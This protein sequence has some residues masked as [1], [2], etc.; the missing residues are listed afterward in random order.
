MDVNHSVAHQPP[1]A[2]P[3]VLCSLKGEEY[4]KGLIRNSGTKRSA[5]PDPFPYPVVGADH[6]HSIFELPIA[7]LLESCSTR[8]D[9][10][11][12]VS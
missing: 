5:T 8:T 3:L 10:R 2:F 11:H 12:K 4:L 7:A 1:A 6:Y 9:L